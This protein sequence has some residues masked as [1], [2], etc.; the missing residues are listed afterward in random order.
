MFDRHKNCGATASSVMEEAGAGKKGV[1]DKASYLHSFQKLF[2]D[3]LSC[4]LYIKHY[5]KLL[6]MTFWSMN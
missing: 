6:A 3:I 2:K 1:R 4:D 5:I